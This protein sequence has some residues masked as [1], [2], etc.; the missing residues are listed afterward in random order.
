M[1]F[2]GGGGLMAAGAWFWTISGSLTNSASLSVSMSPVTVYD[3]IGPEQTPHCVKPCILYF[4]TQA[5]CSSWPH[6]K[7][8]ICPLMRAWQT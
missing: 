8:A 7:V 3:V 2:G 4:K 1:S 6:G 5:R